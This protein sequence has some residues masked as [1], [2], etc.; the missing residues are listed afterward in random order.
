MEEKSCDPVPVPEKAEK[1]KLSEKQLAALEKGR[2]KR[3]KLNL[4]KKE[5]DFELI[6]IQE[7]VREAEEEK[8]KYEAEVL[9]AKLSEL[10][11]QNA[12][13]KT[14]LKPIEPASP[15]PEKEEPVVI[16]KP[17]VVPP[18]KAQKNPSFLDTICFC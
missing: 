3:R 2:E 5:A 13:L 7:R 11:S 4:E 1:K 9:R 6:K 18:S 16:Q 15:P 14:V 8:K 12:K 17:A 10:E